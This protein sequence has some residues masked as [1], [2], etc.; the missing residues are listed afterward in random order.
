MNKKLFL[1]AFLAAFLATL[2]NKRATIFSGIDDTDLDASRDELK[3]LLESLDPNN[4][5]VIALEQQFQLN[6]NGKFAHTSVQ[7]KN[8]VTT[9]F[10]SVTATSTNATALNQFIDGILPEIFGNTTKFNTFFGEVATSILAEKQTNEDYEN[11]VRNFN[12]L[13]ENERSYLVG[14]SGAKSVILL[15]DKDKTPP[16]ET[17]SVAVT[18]LS[19]TASKNEAGFKG[20]LLTSTRFDNVS[21]ELVSETANVNPTNFFKNIVSTIITA[22]L[23]AEKDKIADLVT[24]SETVRNFL[25]N[26]DSDTKILNEMTK[27]INN[28]TLQNTIAFDNLYCV[29]TLR[30]ATPDTTYTLNLQAPITRQNQSLGNNVAENVINTVKKCANALR[31]NVPPLIYVYHQLLNVQKEST[32]NV[33]GAR[34]CRANEA[35][36][37][38]D[39]INAIAKNNAQAAIRANE[40]QINLAEKEATITAINTELVK[41]TKAGVRKSVAIA[42]LELTFNENENPQMSKLISATVA[43]SNLAD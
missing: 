19:F 37:L 34:P 3:N 28:G 13:P 32:T 23:P 9:F 35:V 2:E 26:P 8:Y 21:K 40:T 33:I 7:A 41:F 10:N 36:T 22:T 1:S 12:K 24:F 4:P 14:N 31:T 16:T 29:L 38:A 5:A 42:R 17:D 11:F 18:A 25:S 43:T 27:A 30:R 39:T 20:I 6:N 15:S